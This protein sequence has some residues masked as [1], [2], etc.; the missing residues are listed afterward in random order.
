MARS[1]ALT[2]DEYLAEL[3]E[4]RRNSLSV[5]R[6]VVLD[7]L[8]EG[9]MEEMQY[10]MISYVVPLATYPKTYNGKPLAYVS[11]ASQKNYMSLYLMS[12]YGDEE[13]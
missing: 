2:V 9:Y 6:R 7:N 4:D 10:G 5:V 3:S 8:P 11:L 13:N 1:E 12:I